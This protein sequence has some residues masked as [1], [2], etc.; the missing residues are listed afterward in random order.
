MVGVGH[1]G[2]HRECSSV[3]IY[4]WVSKVDYTLYRVFGVVGKR[5]CNI[6]VPVTLL[7]CLAQIYVALL[8]FQVVQ[9]RHTEVDLN[10]IAI[11]DICQERLSSW[12]HQC[13]YVG[14]TLADKS[15]DGRTHH[16]V[17]QCYLGLCKV[18]LTHNYLGFCTLVCRYGIVQVEA[19]G[20]I[21]LI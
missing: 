14:T 20:C 2:T 21:L 5:N 8:A 7:D 19:A 11:Y 18:G 12:A 16:S 4:L 9:T 13:S 10:S 15:R 6:W 1:L 3:G 17:A